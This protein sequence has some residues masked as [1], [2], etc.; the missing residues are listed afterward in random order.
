[1]AA[2]VLCCSGAQ[3]AGAAS[4]YRPLAVFLFAA[5]NTDSVALVFRDVCVYFSPDALV[6]HSQSQLK[7]RLESIL[8]RIDSDSSGPD[9]GD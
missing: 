3:Q 4:T 1:M 7:S 9:Q 5:L 8:I 6:F 2:M